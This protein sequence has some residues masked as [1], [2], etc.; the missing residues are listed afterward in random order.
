MHDVLFVSKAL[1]LNALFF[2]VNVFF[3]KFL[4]FGTVIVSRCYKPRLSCGVF[5]ASERR[6]IETP[7]MLRCYKLCCLHAIRGLA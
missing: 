5:L 6:L 3:N 4:S 7:H 2:G 1:I